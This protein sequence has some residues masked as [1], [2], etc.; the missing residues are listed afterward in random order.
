LIVRKTSFGSDSIFQTVWSEDHFE[1]KE[2]GLNT[3]V[4]MSKLGQFCSL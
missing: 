3:T 1:S 2:P 4:A